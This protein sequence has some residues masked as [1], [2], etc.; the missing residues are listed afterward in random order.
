MNTSIFIARIFA[1]AYLTI[2][3]GMIISGSYYRKALEDMMKNAGF[4]YL[5]GIMALIAGYL[6]V[7]YHNIWVNDWTVIVT[8]IGWLALVKGILLLMFPKWMLKISKPIIKMVGTSYGFIP[9]ILGLIF[10]YFGF[11]V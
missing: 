4:M 9:V 2:G 5:G 1:V 3:L 10:G 6:I 7:F 11:I 8:I